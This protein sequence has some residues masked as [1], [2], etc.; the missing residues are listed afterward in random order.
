SGEICVAPLENSANG[1]AV[2]DFAFYRG[3]RIRDLQLRFKEGRAEAVKAKEGLKVFRNVIKN[4]HGD[5]DRIGELGIGMNPSVKRAVGYT[6]T[7]EKIV[8]TVHMAIGENRFLGGRND[9]DLHWDLIVAKP[10]LVM[11]ETKVMDHGRYLV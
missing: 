10:T 4:T 11:G 9:S 8:G 7:D 2:F 5:N 6:L 3:H 1:K